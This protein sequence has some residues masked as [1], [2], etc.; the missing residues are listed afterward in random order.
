MELVKRSDKLENLTNYKAQVYTKNN[1]KFCEIVQ[2]VKLSE[3]LDMKK[4]NIILLL[5]KKVEKHTR[6]NGSVY[7][8]V[9]IS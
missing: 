9:T 6:V 3:F 4:K 1:K 8:K 5:S 2:C 7:L